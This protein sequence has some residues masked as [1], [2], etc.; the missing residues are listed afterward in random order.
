MNFN[1]DGFNERNFYVRKSNDLN[2]LSR[3]KTSNNNINTSLA[4][5]ESERNRNIVETVNTDQVIVPEETRGNI[6]NFVV[7]TKAMNSANTRPLPNNPVS[8]AMR[9]NMFKR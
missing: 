8:Q 4:K 6:D 9:R 5:M 2:K 1:T 7:R 3:N